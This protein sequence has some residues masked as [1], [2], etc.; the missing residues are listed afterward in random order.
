L[1]PGQVIQGNYQGNF[2]T[3]LVPLFSVGYVQPERN[4]TLPTVWKLDLDLFRISDT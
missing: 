2:C 3:A 4:V 1:Y